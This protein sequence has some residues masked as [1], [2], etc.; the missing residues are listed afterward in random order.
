MNAVLKRIGIAIAALVMWLAFGLVVIPIWLIFP[1]ATL[2]WVIKNRNGLRD[3]L[4]RYGQALDSCSNVIVFDGHPKETISSHVGR[5]YSA[6]Y[7]NPDKG[8][9][10]TDANFKLPFM[11]KFV[12]WLTNLG[13]SRHCYKAVEVWAVEAQV[14]L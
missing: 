11:A 4:T 8:L 13:E 7:G 6:K 12:Y 9:V 5:M 10:I 3:R 2:W 1:L 14:P